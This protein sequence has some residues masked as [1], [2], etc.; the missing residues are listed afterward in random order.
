MYLAM[1]DFDSKHERRL[2]GKVRAIVHSKCN[3]A[4]GWYEN[5]APLVVSYLENYLW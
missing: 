3:T 4:I 1:T 5:Y 2:T